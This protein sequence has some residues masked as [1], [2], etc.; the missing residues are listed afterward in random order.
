VSKAG[1]AYWRIGLEQDEGG[2][3]WFTSF[4]EQSDDAI[5]GKSVV[6]SLKAW[7][8]GVVVE[9]LWEAVDPAEVPF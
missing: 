2:V 5:R 8:D 9:D 3:E 4:K 6:L 7:K 1:K